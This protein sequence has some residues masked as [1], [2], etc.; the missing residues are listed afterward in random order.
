MSIIIKNGLIVNS[1]KVFKSDILIKGSKIVRISKEILTDHKKDIKIIDATDKYVLPGAI[2]PHVHMHLPTPAGFSADDFLSGS[3]AAI[4]GGTTTIID[5][6]TPKKGQSLIE[7]Y[8]LRKQE[9]ENSLVNTYFHVT[10]VDF[11]KN[12][13]SEIKQLVQ[14]GIKSFKVYTAYNIGLNDY[15]LFNVMKSVAQYNGILAVHCENGKEIDKLRDL[16]FNNGKTSPKYHPLSRPDFTEADAVEKVINFSEQT[17]CKV[18]IVHTSA[19]KS[20]ELINKAQAK[21]IKIFSETCPQYLLFD[22]KKL[23][24]DF[25]DTAKFVFSPPLRTKIDN[26]AL[27]DAI[28][29]GVISTIG[30]DH[31]PFNFEQKNLGINDFRKIPNGAGGVENRLELLFTFG[32]LQDRITINKFVELVAE[33]PAKI[34]GLY[35]KKGIIAENSDADVVVWNPKTLKTISAQEQASNC[36]LNI[37]EGIETKGEAEFVIIGGKFML[38]EN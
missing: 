3:K 34:F 12:T 25:L 21:G 38:P 7:A 17:G 14:N 30:T 37:Y 31:C 33:N 26:A 5:F 36:D 19:K 24:G 23:E 6:V 32:V 22:D 2:D 29:S 9:A 13:D 8:N 27:W 11:N 35:P 1:D 20:V 4:K 15:D 18:Y 28:K 10:P 16:Y